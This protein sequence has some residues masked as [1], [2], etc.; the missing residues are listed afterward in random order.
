MLIIYFFVSKR[1]NQGPS[2]ISRTDLDDKYTKS[3]YLFMSISYLLS[4]IYQ[5]LL[6]VL[7]PKPELTIYLES[8]SRDEILARVPIAIPSENEP[9]RAIFNYENILIRRLIWLLKYGGSQQIGL[10][11][12]SILAEHILE[13]LSD[14]AI[15]GS[16]DKLILLP[17]PLGPL[18]I[19][20]RGYN[21]SEIICRGMI[22]YAPE[23]LDLRTDILYKIKE[24][25]KQS[26]TKNKEER[27]GN[28]KGSFGVRTPVSTSQVD[29]GGITNIL[30]GRTVLLVDDV[31]T[32]G[33]TFGEASRTLRAAGAKKVICYA[34]AH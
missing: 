26:K 19:D 8:M 22:A 9:F 28:L 4:S 27:L 6:D 12:G 2:L 1:K 15:F 34:L 5:F 20:K 29:T 18:V 32:T 11:L 21:Q 30:T 31:V 3:F 14:E 16:K 33:A 13:D 10:T 17:V 25:G 24:T 7:F 23:I